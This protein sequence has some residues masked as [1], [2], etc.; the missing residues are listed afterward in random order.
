MN[1]KPSK[2]TSSI[3]GRRTLAVMKLLAGMMLTSVFVLTACKRDQPSSAAA[4]KPAAH[5]GHEH[6]HEGHEHV[7]EVKL[8][9]ESI[10][11]YGVATDLVKKHALRSTVV[12]PAEV[13]FNAD[14]VAHVGSPL[15]GRVVEISARAGREVKKGDELCV[16]ESPEL[17]EAQ[18]D[19]LQRRVAQ[20]A[21]APAVALAKA[22]WDRARSLYEQSQGTSL[23]EVQRR[24]AEHGS[25]V[26]AQLGADAAFTAAESRLRLMGMDKAAVD[27]LLKT[28]EVR[29]RHTLRA[30]INGQVIEREVT[31]GE[32]V[33][34]DRERLM[35]LADVTSVWVM[36]AVP[37]ALVGEIAVGTKAWIRVGPSESVPIGGQVAHVAASVDASTRSVQVRIEVAAVDG[38]IKPGM[39]ARVEIVLGSQGAEPAPVVA[40]PDVAVQTVE[41][42]PAVFVPVEGEPNTFAKRAV[43]VGKS[44]GG[45]VP[46]LSGLTEGEKF[47]VSGSFILKAELGKAG[48][49]HQH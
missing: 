46:I 3:P 4:A 37:E 45:L 29:P 10:V 44:V 14:A 15:R 34:P 18:A 24:E 19:L 13:D 41:G 26:A 31:L 27:A 32:L 30:S 17:G 25:L 43:S 38:L 21:S 6:E 1:K 20:K 23:A 8:T 39:F 47:V 11:R 40:V 16:I 22:S 33:G 9:A 2:R 36:A 7:D 49:S 12:V 5:D 28:G 42:G 35:V 48:A